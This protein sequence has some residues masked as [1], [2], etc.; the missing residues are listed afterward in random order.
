MNQKWDCPICMEIIVKPMISNC[1]HTIC[2]KCCERRFK[3]CPICKKKN[4]K[5]SLNVIFND[6]LETDLEIH[7]KYLQRVREL[8]EENPSFIIKKFKETKGIKVFESNYSDETTVKIIE[9][10]KKCKNDGRCPTF[11]EQCVFIL[12]K[13]GCFSIQV[14]MKYGFKC[15][16]D[17]EEW[18]FC[19]TKNELPKFI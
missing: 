19:S 13:G 5:Y 3:E 7:E 9:L 4:I 6:L 11:E 2:G 8:E 18:S 15:N 10:F 1:G 17:N 14:K 16:I 12:N